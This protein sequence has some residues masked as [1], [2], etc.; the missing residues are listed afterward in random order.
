M[1]QLLV[2]LLLL[3]QTRIIS[4]SGSSMGGATTVTSISTPSGGGTPDLPAGAEI[5]LNSA[6]A[7]NIHKNMVLGVSTLDGAANSD[8]VNRWVNEG[9]LHT[10]PTASD[11]P[12]TGS[13]CTNADFLFHSFQLFGRYITDGVPVIAWKAADNA[14]GRNSL[15][16]NAGACS[17]GTRDPGTATFII[18]ARIASY[19]DNSPQAS[20]ESAPSLFADLAR[21]SWHWG[22]GYSTAANPAGPT[23][24]VAFHTNNSAYS[25]ETN[26]A[27]GVFDTT[28]YHVYVM[29]GDQANVLGQGTDKWV[30]YVDGALIGS[31]TLTNVATFDRIEMGGNAG[32]EVDHRTKRVLYYN[33]TL[34][35]PQIADASAALKALYGTP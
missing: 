19:L 25:A 29:A 8:F 28:T 21:G 9:T 11:A 34:T 4:K 32:N 24:G 26:L 6:T 20:F 2:A 14:A 17:G 15:V 7:A 10:V 18:V 23:T 31:M 5:D 12:E 22:I 35:A 33:S 13:S 3:Q 16:W 1:K 30:C 27:A